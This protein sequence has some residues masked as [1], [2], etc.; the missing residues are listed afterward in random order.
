MMK[1]AVIGVGCGALRALAR[2]RPYASRITAIQ[3]SRVAI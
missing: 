2:E 1:M 3:P